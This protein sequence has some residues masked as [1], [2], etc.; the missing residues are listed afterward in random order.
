MIDRVLAGLHRLGQQDAGPLSQSLHPANARLCLDS[1]IEA[2]TAQ[3]LEA[4]LATPGRRPDDVTLV[5]A[6]GVF[7]SP[8]EWAALLLAA[9]CRLRIKAPSSAPEL[10]RALGEAMGAEGLPVSVDVE[11]LLGEP[12]AIIGFGSDASMAAVAAATPGSRHSLYGHRFSIAWV[13]SDPRAAAQGLAMD[14]ARY[15]GR[16]CMAPAAVFTTAD[17][18][19]LGEALASELAAMQSRLPRGPVDPALGPEWRRRTGLA[20]V[21]GRCLEG[22][23]WAVPV[24]DGAYLSPSALPRMLPVHGVAD[25]AEADALL[26]RFS[27]QLSSCGTDS[28]GPVP[29]GVLRRCGLG[30]LQTPRFP[31]AHDGRPMLGSIL[32]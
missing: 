29:Q 6:A 20:R 26:S 5:V 10:C 27:H 7:T 11:R 16:G 12:G 31:R 9:G 23:E 17:P 4:E 13:T 25:L 18:L 21:L 24:L 32:G 2:I 1:A 28:E 19:E 8:I 22:P 14:A 3:G 30:E 15:D